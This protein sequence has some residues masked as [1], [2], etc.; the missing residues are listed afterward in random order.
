[1]II[2]NINYKT[3]KEIQRVFE[4]DTEKGTKKKEFRRAVVLVK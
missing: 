2:K 4:D 1:M 3:K